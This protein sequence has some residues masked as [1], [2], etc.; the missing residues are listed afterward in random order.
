MRV[1]PAEDIG[2]AFAVRADAALVFVVRFTVF[3]TAV[4]FW[5]VA[6]DFVDLIG[7]HAPLRLSAERSALLGLSFF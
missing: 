1:F 3:F 5:A 4:V 2:F 7:I 6:V